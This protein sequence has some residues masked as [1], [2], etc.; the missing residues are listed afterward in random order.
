M[1]MGLVV[2][3]A[4]SLHNGE[5]GLRPGASYGNGTCLWYIVGT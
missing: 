2:L 4:F 5:G 1:V 3:K